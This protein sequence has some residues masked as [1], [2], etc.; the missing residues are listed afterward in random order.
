VQPIRPDHLATPTDTMLTSI[1][2]RLQ[3]EKFLTTPLTLPLHPFYLIRRSLYLT[4][5]ECASG[6]SGR[7]LDFGCGSKPYES[8]FSQAS[9]YVGV[10]LQASGHDHKNSKVDVF[11]DGQHLPFDAASFDAVVSFEVFEHIFEL[12]QSLQEIKRVL[13]PDGKLLISIPFAWDEHEA[14]F[15]H[16]RYTSYGI[17]HMLERNGFEVKD[18]RKSNSYVRAL[19]QLWIAYLVQHVLPQGRILSK[20]AQLLV[21]F[22]TTLLALLADALLPRR[23]QFFSNCVVMASKP[24]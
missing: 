19:A 10:D 3:R 12:D 7:V 14:P 21:V 1:K 20:V 6:I 18:V 23:D 22:P 13:K 24:R 5:R 4:I 11:Y 2:A 8:L 9:A 17:Q 16:A 15:D